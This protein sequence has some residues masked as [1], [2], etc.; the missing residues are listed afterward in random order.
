MRQAIL[1][2]ALLLLGS[3]SVCAQSAAPTQP[4]AAINA[5]VSA[6]SAPVIK[7]GK[8]GFP[9]SAERAN[10][11]RIPRLE[12]PPVIDGKLD[13]GEWQGAVL[14]KDFFQTDPGYNVPASEPTAVRMA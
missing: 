14:F 8:P 3:L 7:S 9:L 4:P 13:E 2:G 11:V 6:P 12:K 5:S 1:L 10:P